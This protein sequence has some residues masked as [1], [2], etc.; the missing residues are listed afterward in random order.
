[1]KKIILPLVLGLIVII[2][3]EDEIVKPVNHHPIIFSL[4]VFPEVVNPSDSLIVICNAVD[5]DADTL[6]YDWYTIGVVKIKGAR[7]NQSWLLHTYEN[8]RIFYAPDSI[9]VSAPQDTFRVEC[10]TRDVKGGVD[11]KEVSFIVRKDF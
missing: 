3:C 11:V 4:T 8:S 5:P 1:M 2:S 6:V 10:A 7:D 9:Y